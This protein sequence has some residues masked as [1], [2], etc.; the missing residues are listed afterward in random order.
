[1][2]HT[3]LFRPKERLWVGVLCK[4]EAVGSIE[5]RSGIE[6]RVMPPKGGV[7]PEV[8]L[9]KGIAKVVGVLATVCVCVDSTGILWEG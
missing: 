1:M 5:L 2:A 7:A 9:S 3:L 8:G 6:L 4:G